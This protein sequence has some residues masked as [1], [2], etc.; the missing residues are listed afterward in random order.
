G[1]PG[2]C[3]S[4]VSYK[5]LVRSLQK[6]KGGFL[7]EMKSLE[8]SQELSI[9]QPEEHDQLLAE[10]EDVFHLPRGLPL[11]R[12]H[13]HAIVLKEGIIP[14][15]VRPYRYPYAQKNEIERLVKEMLEAGVIQPSSSPFLSP[16]LLVKKKDGSWRFCVDYKSLNKSTILDKFPIPV[17]DE[18][19]DELHSAT[20]FSKLDLKSGY[21]QI[22]MKDDDVSKTAFRT[23][24]GH[25]KFLVMPSG[26]TN[27]PAKFQSL[28][29]K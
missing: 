27:V 26:L 3:R 1:D 5:A 2:L 21:H 17:I 28:M 12:D 23:H 9:K 18:L 11:Q 7:V 20:M 13:E 25:Y 8:E 22:R 10:F 15:S 19:L 24:E 6:E 4:L 29:N 14:I 16:V